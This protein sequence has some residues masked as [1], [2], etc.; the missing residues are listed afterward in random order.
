MTHA[1]LI[2]S[3]D[4]L[5]HD[6]DTE[7]AR[8][9]ARYRAA[10]GVGIEL[11]GLLGNQAENLFERLPQQTRMHID[12]VTDQSL[13]QAMKAAHESQSVIG[14]RVGWLNSA[15]AGAL[16]AA[17]GLGGIPTALAELPVTTMILLREIQSEAVRLGFDP[18][19]ENV[20]F[21]C[22]QVFGSAGPLARDDGTD[23]SFV[24][25]RMALASGSMQALIAKIV[26]KLSVV[27]GKKLAAQSVPVFGAVAGAA[28][29]YAYVS[30]YREMSHV[31][32]G[33]RKLS[34]DSGEDHSAL[35]ADLKMRMKA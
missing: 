19:S 33:L 13:R 16:G 28:I 4:H 8:L 14:D 21:D 24:G 5:P 30:Y 7:L 2:W 11:L 23:M 35:V 20:Q 12:R 17:G 9:A 15:M 25:A 3:D 18:A 10:G 32:F 6:T 27:L 26:P 34:I 22:I 31:H 29:N 1:E